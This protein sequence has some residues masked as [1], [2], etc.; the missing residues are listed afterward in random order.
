MLS[1]LTKEVYVQCPN[2][3]CAH[4]GKYF[5]SFVST[6]APSMRPNPKAYV[7]VGPARAL[8]ADSRQLD[9]AGL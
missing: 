2:V 5:V 3:E 6:V 8:P 4:T 1:L 7:P 9:L